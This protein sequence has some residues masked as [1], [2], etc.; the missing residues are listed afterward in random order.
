MIRL[1]DYELSGNCYK[2]R[3]LMHWLGLPFERI[4]V[5]FHPGRAHKSDAFVQNVNPLGQLPVLDDD[6]HYWVGEDEARAAQEK[7]QAATDETIKRVDEIVKAL[8]AHAKFLRGALGRHIDMRFTPDLRF[9][10]DDTFDRMDETRRLFSQEQVR[11]D[12]EAP[13]T[14]DEGDDT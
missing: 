13:A 8:N 1:Y 6:K 7:V 2:L 5:D 14:D 11:R 9:R 3:L 4:P 10:I 12:V